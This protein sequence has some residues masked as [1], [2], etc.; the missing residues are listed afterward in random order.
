MQV[1]NKPRAVQVAA[2][3]KTPNVFDALRGLMAKSAQN[4]WGLAD[5]TAL[6][7]QAAGLLTVG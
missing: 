7:K 5:L 2:L 6:K 3:P 1:E 4:V